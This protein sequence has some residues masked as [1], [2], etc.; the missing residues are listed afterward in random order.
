MIAIERAAEY[1]HCNCC[2][3]PGNVAEIYFRYNDAGFPIGHGQVIAL[4]ENCRKTLE[5][6][7][8]KYRRG[9][10]K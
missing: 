4:C 6:E 5:S 7:L 1:R 10:C 8:I 9:G 3:N 2:Q